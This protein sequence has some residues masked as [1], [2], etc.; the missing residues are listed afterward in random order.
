MDN[1]EM[2]R[3]ALILIIISPVYLT[4]SPVFVIGGIVELIKWLWVPKQLD[5]IRFIGYNG[6]HGPYV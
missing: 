1:R 3:K 2:I 4:L 6:N 5:K